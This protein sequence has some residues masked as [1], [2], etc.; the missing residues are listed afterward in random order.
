MFSPPDWVLNNLMIA[1]VLT[2]GTLAIEVAIGVLV[3]KQK[4][5]PWV[6]AMGV[7]LH[8]SISVF[9]EVGF[10]SAAMFVLYLAFIPTDRVRALVSRLEKRVSAVTERFGRQD[11]DDDDDVAESINLDHTDEDDI[12]VPERHGRVVVNG[13]AVREPV[14][15]P[16]PVGDVAANGGPAMNGRRVREP[17]PGPKRVPVP[18]HIVDDEPTGRHARRTPQPM[19][20]AIS[21]DSRRHVRPHRR[22]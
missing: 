3:W 5:R 6:L 13:R 1:N 14:P 19:T 12:R 10:F 22:C 7:A 18:P 8:L 4:W 11:D 21:A 20:V 2:W 15:A 16:R 9:L 17:M